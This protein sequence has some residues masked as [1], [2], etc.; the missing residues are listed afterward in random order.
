LKKV[1]VTEKFLLK[2][3]EMA[4]DLYGLADM[5]RNTELKKELRK[6]INSAKKYLGR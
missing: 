1:P 2:S 5:N 3:L 6:H 4:E